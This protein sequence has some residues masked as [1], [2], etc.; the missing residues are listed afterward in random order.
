MVR[1]FEAW[2]RH[3]APT[4][5]DLEKQRLAALLDEIGICRFHSRIAAGLIPQEPAR[6]V[7]DEYIR[8]CKRQGP[9]VSV[10]KAIFT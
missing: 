7:V 3:Q 8:K 9:I 2:R 5:Q 4:P 6:E 1:L 10:L